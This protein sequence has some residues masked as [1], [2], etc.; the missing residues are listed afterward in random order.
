MVRV[1]CEKGCTK[2]IVLWAA[3]G[4]LCIHCPNI[5]FYDAGRVVWARAKEFERQYL[6]GELELEFNPQDTL[7]ER[8]RAGG[9]R[10]SPPSSPAPA[11]A[12]SWPGAR[13]PANS[14][15]ITTCLKPH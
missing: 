14:T 6:S 2:R 4:C 8:L 3:L 1:Q 11:T 15:A 9:A 12:P 5:L 10:E 7:A 13:R